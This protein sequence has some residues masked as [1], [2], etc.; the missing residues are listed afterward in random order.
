MTNQKDIGSQLQAALNAAVESPDTNFP[1]AML[2]VRS[3]EFGPWAGAAGLGELKTNTAMRPD[4]RFRAGSVIKPFVS[5]VTLQL[6]EEGR[7]SLDDP[8]PGVLPGDV[9]G[10]FAARDEI[11]VR[12]LLN[13]TSGIADWLTE[14]AIAEVMA[15]PGRVREVDEYLDLAA[16]QEPYFAP[17]KGWRYSN[18]DYNLL[19]VVIA[20]ATGRSWRK[21][22]R[23]RVFEP[24]HLEDT[25]LPEPGDLSIPGNY[26]HGYFFMEGEALDVT[27]VDPSMAGAAGGHALV[28][29]TTDLARF[30]DALLAGELFRYAETL[31]E[32]LTFV[33]APEGSFPISEAAGY[34]LGMMKYVLPGGIEMLGHGGDTA[35]FSGFVYYLPAQDITIS[36]VINAM[37]PMS[38]LPQIIYPTLEMLV[39][40]FSP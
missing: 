31:D 28:T 1:G 29:T 16:A 19:G 12:M 24:L 30:L 15:N 10:R 38:V 4:D 5:V 34:S 3:P 37:E 22:V 39:R 17:G 14:A 20:Q 13:H 25:L 27:A 8:L 36:G 35:G 6:V 33:D 26:A 32:M 9:T 2:Y 40:E 11:T 23:Q 18:T 21:A 7:F